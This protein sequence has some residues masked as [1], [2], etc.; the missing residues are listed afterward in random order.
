M[1]GGGG[2]GGNTTS[3]VT[4]TNLPEYVQPYVEKM[5][6]QAESLV[7]Q[8]YQQYTGQQT[9]AINPLQTQGYQQ[10]Q[11]MVPSG[12]TGQAG[13]MA[14]IA[15]TNRFTGDT[16]QQ[17]MSPYMQNVVDVQKNQAVSDYARSIP[18]MGATAARAGGLGGTRQALVQA[19]GQRNLGNQLT[20]I[21]ATG[22]QN[23][24]QNA[25][26]QFNSSQNQMLQGA[27]LLG[28]MGQQQYGQQMGIANA[29]IGAGK[30]LQDIEQQALNVPYQNWQ[31]QVNYPYQQLSYLN[32]LIRGLPQPTNIYSTQQG[33]SPNL[34][35]ALAGAAAGGKAG[36]RVRPKSQGL[37]SL[38]G[39]TASKR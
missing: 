20:N 9:A 25:Q 39:K 7:N 33:S 29:Q 36:G 6:G 26:N 4:Q 17:Y 35:G 1:C 12:M 13:A 24:F 5:L 3:T 11:Q 16:A 32:S 22:L 18:G 30:G 10:L 34:L 19:E 23:A 14:G 15:A 37:G 8:P 31:N 2:G 27:Q 21:Q 38:I 28:N